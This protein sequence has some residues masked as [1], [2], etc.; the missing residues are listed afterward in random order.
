MHDHN[1]AAEAAGTRIARNFAHTTRGPNPK[2]FRLAGDDLPFAARFEVDKINR[3]IA[4]ATNM[5]RAERR[6]QA[7]RD[8]RLL[9]E[10]KDMRIALRD[11]GERATDALQRAEQ[12]EAREIAA[13]ERSEMRERLLVKYTITGVV[14]GALSLIVAAVTVVLAI[15]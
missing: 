2:R 3:I 10:V 4:E 9:A 8:E 15:T 14:V 1:P 12:A 6:A 11:A 13:R 5:G 7:E